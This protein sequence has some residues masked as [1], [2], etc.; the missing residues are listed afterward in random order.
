MEL[1][2]VK[3]ILPI[4]GDATPSAVIGLDERHPPYYPT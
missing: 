2:K 3:A 4:T 1:A